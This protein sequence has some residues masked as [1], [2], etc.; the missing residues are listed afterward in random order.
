MP[1]D[2]D[3]DELV[4]YLL[5]AGVGAIPVVLALSYRE[6]FATEATIGL[7]MLAGSLVGLA[8]LRHVRRQ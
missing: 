4:L 1:R 2:K 5:I 8:T 3:D 7:L 6:V